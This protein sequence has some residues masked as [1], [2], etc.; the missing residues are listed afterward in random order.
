MY[1]CIGVG[2]DVLVVWEECLPIPSHS[3]WYDE[4]GTE[5]K[6]EDNKII[7]TINCYISMSNQ[8]LFESA[9]RDHVSRFVQN[10]LKQCIVIDCVKS[11]RRAYAMLEL[12]GSHIAFVNMAR[13]ILFFNVVNHSK[14][15]MCGLMWECTYKSTF[16]I[17]HIEYMFG[18][19]MNL[20]RS[21][22]CLK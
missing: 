16:F 9:H 13:F 12:S 14:A 8:L 2:I 18:K 6:K 7:E 22:F 15:N 19:W 5:G 3:N 20:V 21:G 11:V 1:I 4:H 17:F 10:R